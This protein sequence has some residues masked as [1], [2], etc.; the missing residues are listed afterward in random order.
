MEPPLVTNTRPSPSLLP[1]SKYNFGGYYTVDNSTG[2]TYLYLTGR[3]EADGFTLYGILSPSGRLVAYNTVTRATRQVWSQQAGNGVL[4]LSWVPTDAG[5][6][7]P[8]ASGTPSNTPSSSGTQTGTPSPSQTPSNTP[9]MTAS[10][11]VTQTSSLSVGASPSNTAT[12]SN[13]VGIFPANSIVVLRSGNG[14]T[15]VFGRNGIAAPVFLDVYDPDAIAVGYNFTPPLL[16]LAM[17]IVNATSGLQ[18]FRC[19]L[20][21]GSFWDRTATGASCSGNGKLLSFPCYDVTPGTNLTATSSLAGAPLTIA[22]VRADGLIDTTTRPAQSYASASNSLFPMV[23]SAYTVSGAGFYLGGSSS[24][25]NGVRYAAYGSTGSSAYMGN[26][27]DARTVVV[28]AAFN[29]IGPGSPTGTDPVIVTSSASTDYRGLSW[30]PLQTATNASGL[31]TNFFLLPGFSNQAQINPDPWG[32][33][34]APNGK[35]YVSDSRSSG[36][37]AVYSFNAVLNGWTQSEWLPTGEANPVL[38]LCGREEGGVTVLYAV[39]NSLTAFTSAV[40]R[41][42]TATRVSTKIITSLPATQLRAVMLPPTTQDILDVKPSATPSNLPT[43]TSGATGTATGT[44]AATPAGTATASVSATASA[45]ATLSVGGVPSE[46]PSPSAGATPTATPWTA[47]FRPNM[48]IA[49][50]GGNTTAA[51][52]PTV[53]LRLLPLF[54]DVIDTAPGA[55]VRVVDTI[56]VPPQADASTGN[57]GCTLA[58]QN[59]GY[60]QEGF[61]Q[62]SW[63][64]SVVTWACHTI[65]PGLAQPNNIVT[66]RT[67]AILRA[68]GSIDTRTTISDAYNGGTG[69]SFLRAVATVDGTAF[70]LAGF[71]PSGANNGLRYAAYTGGATSTRVIYENP[72]FSSNFR[73]LSMGPTVAAPA[74]PQLFVGMRDPVPFRG[75]TAV[76]AGMPTTLQPVDS[77]TTLLPG[78]DLWQYTSNAPLVLGFTFE[79][80]RSLW[81]AD[82]QSYQFSPALPT[83][84]LVQ[85]SFSDAQGIWLRSNTILV[86]A[87]RQTQ[88]LIGRDEGGTYIL[89]TV[90]DTMLYRIDTSTK[91]VTVVSNPPAGSVYFAVALP[92]VRADIIA[93]S[94]STT[95]TSSQTPSNSPTS[96]RSTSQSSTPTPSNTGSVSKTP[97]PTL[98]P[99]RTAKPS[100]SPTG[101]SSGTAA[102]TVTA[103]GTASN[104]PSQSATATASLSAGA[105]VS[106]TPSGTPSPSTTGTA[107][108]TPSITATPSNTQTGTPSTSLSRTPARSQTPTGSAEPTATPT[109]SNTPSLTASVSAGATASRTATASPSRSNTPA[110]V[111]DAAVLFGMTM[112]GATCSMFASTASLG[113]AL[114]CALSLSIPMPLADVRLGGTTCENGTVIRF[115]PTDPLNTLVAPACAGQARRLAG[116]AASLAA[117]A[118]LTVVTSLAAFGPGKAIWYHDA[119]GAPGR[120]AFGSIGGAAGGRRLASTATAD[121]ELVVRPD[122]E[123]GDSIASVQDKQTDRAG[124][125]IESLTNAQ[126]VAN[127]E[128]SSPLLDEMSRS[129]FLN[130]FQSS[131]GTSLTT[132]SLTVGSALVD[133]PSVTATQTGTPTQTAS[134]SQTG[135]QTGTP[136]SSQTATGTPSSSQTGTGTPSSS[137]TGTGSASQTASQTGTPSQTQTGTGSASQTGTPSQ[138][139]TGTGSASQTGTPSQTQTGTGSQSQTATSSASSTGSVSSTGTPSSTMTSTM[140]PTMTA[141]S[142]GTG[143]ASPSGTGTPSSSGSSSPSET[144]TASQTK[145]RSISRTN[146]PPS[147]GT[148]TQTATPSSTRT[149]SPTPS[150]SRTGTA[151]STGTRTGTGSPSETATPSLSG[152]RTPPITRT[153]TR[154]GSPST[155]ATRTG[156]PSSSATKSGTPAVT[157]TVTPTRSPVA[158]SWS[159]WVAVLRVGDAVNTIKAAAG[160]ALPLYVDYY[161]LRPGVGRVLSVPLPTTPSVDGKSGAC[162][163]AMGKDMTNRW[164]FATEGFPSNSADGKFGV[165]PCYNV[166]VGEDL[167]GD[168]GKTFATIDGTQTVSTAYTG[169]ISSIAREEPDANDGWRVFASPNGRKFYTASVAM[170]DAGFRYVNDASKTNADD[171]VVSRRIYPGSDESIT[172][173]T[174]DARSIVLFGGKLF[175]LCGP[176]DVGANSVFQ[177]GSSS[178]PTTPTNTRVLLPG[179]GVLGQAWAFAFADADTLWVSAERGTVKGSV[180]LYKKT[181]ANFVLTYTVQFS[182]KQIYNLVGRVEFGSYV[183]YGTDGLKLFRYDS[184][185][186]AAKINKPV[187]LATADTSVSFRGVFFAGAPAASPSASVSPSRASRS[188]SSTKVRRVAGRHSRR[189]LG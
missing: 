94:P 157:P 51:F 66:P 58:W 184:A 42:N 47:R 57:N 15:A 124:D 145:T 55:A 9:S 147:T 34:V 118:P 116:D 134:P 40:F 41:I 129:G 170:Y 6:L 105:P 163:L 160:K 165:V 90:H 146:T 17:P 52:T 161:S 10:P 16:T 150:F 99:T 141:T 185:N 154:T 18:R 104:T 79:N 152:T 123:A 92:P 103:S 89:Y 73:F 133:V 26:P 115:A 91:A 112:P 114:R 173:G 140:T 82:M 139:Q 128:D 50:R 167:L 109:P 186:V 174:L 117:A 75:V 95:V 151:A 180:M 113:A 179:L 68:D 38:S 107:A 88:H 144:A 44:A 130:E 108:S 187:T 132:D 121:M 43:P 172:A 137:Q 126:S 76:G 19:T 12:P 168:S 35:L 142:S 119:V 77:A 85:W 81:T 171:A 31:G 80:A 29:D 27:A 21:Y 20:A 25:F 46:P 45:S 101:T 96:T 69:F 87:T 32:W 4:G 65:N 183:L 97:R 143:S 14:S 11:S 60:Q 177:I 156:T 120:L 59:S 78:I 28:T 74:S 102:E 162:T 36:S 100:V 64:G 8:T 136:S 178:A 106:A 83:F 7:V 127:P 122:P 138:T 22:V 158:P 131:T 153:R 148:R 164:N 49:L 37:I 33:H 48:M 110:A 1:C 53:N 189:S 176:K 182:T 3:T 84:T 111:A 135:T 67:I 125:I 54:I 62:R 169:F 13:Q 71:A 70:W 63:D 159:D 86:N 188:W 175:A 30:M 56:A 181:G 149:S 39:A 5:L 23:R 155:S 93:A 98:T 72:T 2:V 166:P 24:T 61:M